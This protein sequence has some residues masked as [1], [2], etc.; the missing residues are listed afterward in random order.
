MFSH[1]LPLFIFTFVLLFFYPTLLTGACIRSYSPVNELFFESRYI[2][3]SRGRFWNDNGYEHFAFWFF[4]NPSSFLDFQLD[5]R[6]FFRS[7]FRIWQKI[8]YFLLRTEWVS[9]FEI[10]PYPHRENVKWFE[11]KIFVN[12]FWKKSI[13]P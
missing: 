11:Q 12:F 9:T 5:E 8:V 6:C 10:S 7:Y 13:A 2:Y 3:S 4:Y 1:L